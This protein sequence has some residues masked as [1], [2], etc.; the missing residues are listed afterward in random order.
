MKLFRP[1]FDS[2]DMW[3]FGSSLLVSMVTFY[4]KSPS[5]NFAAFLL[6]NSFEKIK[7]SKTRSA[8][9]ETL[10]CIT[11]RCIGKWLWLSLLYW[12]DENKRKRVPIM[13]HFLTI[14]CIVKVWWKGVSDRTRGHIKQQ[15][16]DHWLAE[17]QS[18]GSNPDINNLFV[19]NV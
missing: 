11:I 5:S 9:S 12:K 18:R 2:L 4:S 7:I 17:I 15:L 1:E 19:N 6:K 14:R 13:A 10:H 16:L 8:K 3:Y